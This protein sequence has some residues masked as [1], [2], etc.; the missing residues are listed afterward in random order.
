MRARIA[1]GMPDVLGGAALALCGKIVA[2][3]G[4]G[5]SAVGTILDLAQ[6]ERSRAGD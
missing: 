6:L 2:V 3:L 5:H 4:A 1:Y